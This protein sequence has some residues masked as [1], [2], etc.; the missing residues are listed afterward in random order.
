MTT[1]N[2]LPTEALLRLKEGNQRYVSGAAA[3]PHQDAASRRAVVSGQH[4]FAV[5]LT[6]SDSRVSPEILFDQGLGDLFVVRV[7]G[8][9]VDDAVLGSIEYAVR[10]LDTPLVVVLGH[11]QCGAVEAAIRG[12]GDE[13]HITR[14]LE[15]IAPAVEKARALSGNLRDNVID[16]NV[17]QSVAGVKDDAPLAPLMRE[18][19]LRVVGARYHLDSGTV[20]WLD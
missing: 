11:D 10:H 17:R 13:G 16:T 4:P 1:G 14:L 20:D 3:H 18:G 15:A 2:L 12:G 8:N 19:R 6:C 5:I 9:I 7:A